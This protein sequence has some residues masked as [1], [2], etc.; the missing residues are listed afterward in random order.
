MSDA[1]EIANILHN[2]EGL[3]DSAI[4]EIV[5]VSREYINKIRSGKKTASL[6][7]TESLEEALESLEEALDMPPEPSEGAAHTAPLQAPVQYTVTGKD[8]ICGIVILMI[9]LLIIGIWQLHRRHKK[10]QRDSDK[11]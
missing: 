4:G 9:A 7:L 2:E 3:S 10:K 11:P 1:Q 6:N 8:A 5:G